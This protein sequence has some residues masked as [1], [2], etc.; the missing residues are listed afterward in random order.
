M[1]GHTGIGFTTQSFGGESGGLPLSNLPQQ[2]NE[3]RAAGFPREVGYFARISAV[4]KRFP[5]ICFTASSRSSARA[6]MAGQWGRCGKY[7]TYLFPHCELPGLPRA[8]WAAQPLVFPLPNR[9]EVNGKNLEVEPSRTE[10][11]RM[12]GFA[13]GLQLKQYCESWYIST[14][15]LYEFSRKTGKLKAHRLL[16]SE[17]L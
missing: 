8:D 7:A 2:C 12:R 1:V 5:L 3:W 13:G 11:F 10:L 9:L 6:Q 4:H 14:M 17:P 15:C 16:V